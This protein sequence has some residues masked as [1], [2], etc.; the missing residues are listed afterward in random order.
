M[1]YDKNWF[2]LQP[3]YNFIRKQAENEKFLKY[4]E[5]GSTFTLV[6]IFLFFAIMPTMTTIFSLLGEIKSKESFIKKVDSKITNI[7]KAQK[8][9]SQVQ[10][11]YSLIEESFPSQPQYYNGASNLATLFRDSSLGINQI[12]FNLNTETIQKEN[13]SQFFKSYQIN[14]TGE[15]QY[16][17]IMEMLKQMLNNRRLINTSNILISQTK[18]DENETGSNMVNINFFNDLYFLPDN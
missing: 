12:N 11:K 2:Q 5:I 10:E 9:Y 6:A 18:T 13:N 3:M 17:A 7:I 14:L 8:E 4:L 15:G 16:S 1:I